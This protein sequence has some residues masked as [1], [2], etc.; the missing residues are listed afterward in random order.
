LIDVD[1]I[2]NAF[3]EARSQNDKVKTGGRRKGE[4]R[5][6]K[7]KDIAWVVTAVNEGGR[8]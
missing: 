8:K 5:A 4:T 2:E 1:E 6:L 7:W 3:L